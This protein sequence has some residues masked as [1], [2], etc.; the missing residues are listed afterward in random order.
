[1]AAQNAEPVDSKKEET[2]KD[3]DV[4][5]GSSIGPPGMMMPIV[6]PK[7]L[8]VTLKRLW[9][10]FGKE[11][12]MFSL[13]VFLVI[14]GSGLSLIGPYLIGRSI[15]IMSIGKGAVKF[16]AL[17]FI[18]I[19][20]TIAYLSEAGINVLQGWIMAGISQRIV[21]NLRRTLFA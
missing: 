12:R 17:G 5:A 7:N 11:K 19:T 20:L 6:K 4:G 15:D 3:E 16:G 10:Y 13:V 9:R 14:A 18:V 8:K 1:M 21:Q 2:R